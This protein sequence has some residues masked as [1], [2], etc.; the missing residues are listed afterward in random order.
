MMGI[1]HVTSERGYYV[2]SWS[3]Y[4]VPDTF[5]GA[6]DALVSKLKMDHSFNFNSAAR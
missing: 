1:M 6:Q 5:L 2:H 4:T 3:I